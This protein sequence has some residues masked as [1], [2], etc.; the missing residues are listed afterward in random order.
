MRPK[1]TRWIKCEPGERCFR[2]QCNSKTKLEGVILSLDEFEAVRFADWEGLSQEEIAG[3]MKVHRS[4]ISR[5]LKSAR[6]KIAD[7]LVNIKA[8]KVEGGCCSVI[9]GKKK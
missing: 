7:A 1:K 6:S 9:S 3:H 8:I 2:P 5:I 4:T